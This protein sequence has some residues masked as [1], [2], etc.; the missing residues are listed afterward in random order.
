MSAFIDRAKIHVASGAGGDGV[1]MWR[2]EKFV[3]AGGPAGGNGGRGGSVYLVATNDLN[4]LLDFRFNRKFV[5]QPGEK[6]GPKNMHGKAS[7]DIEVRVPVG[8]VVYDAKTREVLAD[9][10]EDGQRWLAAKGGK[11]GRGNAEFVTPTRKAPDFAEPGQAGELLDL[12]LEL[13]LL[14]DIGLVGLPNAGKSTLISAVSAARPKIADYPFTTLAPNL[15]VISFGPGD[16]AVMAD[17]PG[18]VEGASEGVGLGHE[19]L[20]HVERCRLLVHL[21]DLSGGLE[22]RDP[23][24][25][26]AMINQ[27]LKRYSPEIAERPM[28]VVLNKVDLPEAQENRERVES[29]IRAQGYDLF[30]ISAA[31]RENLDQLLNYLREKVKTLP[32]PVVFTPAPRVIVKEEEPDATIVKENGLWQVR[33]PRL[34]R[35]IANMNPEAAEA[36]TKLH[37]ILDEFG[38]VE[39]LREMG[40][41]DGET[42]AIGEF[43][44]DFVE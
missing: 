30:A 21:L 34:E 29:A 26:F 11:G 9:L 35:F 42:V 28:V 2:R 1:V 4:T 5:A 38:V 18:L 19:F 31:T 20:R 33:Q 27:E 36:I 44:F 3:A 16:T 7:P 41:K 43:E 17:I 23:L 13:K 39:R 40:V 10:H 6:G 8:T 22:G 25:D 15:G 24:E 14:A 12:E 37:K 32:P